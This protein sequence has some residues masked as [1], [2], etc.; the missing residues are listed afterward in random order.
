MEEIWKDIKDFNNYQISNLGKVKS[1][2]HNKVHG[3]ILKYEK[4]CKYLRVGLS[5]EKKRFN[6]LIHVLVYETFNNYKLKENE[7]V[8]H[9][10]KN[11][12]NNKIDNLKLMTKFKHTSFHHKGKI[13][14]RIYG[15]KA[16][17]SKLKIV[18]IIQIK[19]LLKEKNLTQKE[20][21]KMFNVCQ[22]QTS[23]IKLNKDWKIINE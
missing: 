21:G 19:K 1:F 7:C 23:K 15:E 4:S 20:I 8:H 10:D 6:K 16:P 18:D 9:K 17:N 11:K 12:E 13:G 2:K 3:K 5:K 14:T 22:T